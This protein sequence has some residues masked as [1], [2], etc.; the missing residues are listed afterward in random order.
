MGR[1]AAQSQRGT[2]L[3]VDDD[4]NVTD[5]F[6]R[7]LMLEGYD[8]HMAL[9]AETGLRAVDASGPQAILLDLR[10]PRVDGVAFLR[11]L[12]ARADQC[13]TPVAIITG[14]YFLDDAVTDTL[15]EL[16]ASLF[17]KPLWFDD[18]VEITRGLL[19]PPDLAGPVG[20]P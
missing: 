11:Q 14:D 1:P 10:M 9:D 6:A 4:P 8:V 13:E 3:I 20:T 17:F 12:R 18:L 15:R 5:T 7:L 2:I 19:A 16:G